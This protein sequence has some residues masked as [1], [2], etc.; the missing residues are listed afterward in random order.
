MESTT[1]WLN[2]E[3]DLYGVGGVLAQHQAT[4]MGP[5]VFWPMTRG[6][7]ILLGT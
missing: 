3:G 2:T 7:T 4:L 6:L 5:V 1:F